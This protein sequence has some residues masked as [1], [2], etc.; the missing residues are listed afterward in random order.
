MDWA[1]GFI[2][3]VIQEYIVLN[4]FVGFFKGSF[5]MATV[6][7]YGVTGLEDDDDDREPVELRLSIPISA[8]KDEV[9][10]YLNSIWETFEFSRKEILSKKDTVRFRPR[11]NFI[12]DIRILNKYIEIENLSSKQRKEK[13]V[14][15]IEI[16]VK[17]ELENSG[18][19]NIPDEGTIRS[20]VSRLKNEI[21][22]NS[23]FWK[24][25]E[26]YEPID[27]SK[28]KFDEF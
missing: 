27:M 28:L 11:P 8:K 10:D 21:K 20:I 14:E 17:K 26:K 5:G 13:G 9:K 16:S 4:D 6:E 19:K 3:S 18:M 2:K 22:D 7:T 1:D 15:Y 23:S 12:R 24:E 25:I